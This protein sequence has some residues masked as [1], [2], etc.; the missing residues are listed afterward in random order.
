MCQLPAVYSHLGGKPTGRHFSVN[1]AALLFVQE[2]CRPAG[3]YHTRK[4]VR[5]AGFSVQVDLCK[6]FCSF[7]SVCQGHKKM[8][9]C[10]WRYLAPDKHGAEDDLKA[11]EEVITDD[12]DSRSA[13]RPAF[14]GAD[15]FDC[16]R[17]CTQES[18]NNNN[19]TKPCMPVKVS[20]IGGQITI[21]ALHVDNFCFASNCSFLLPLVF[22]QN[23]VHWK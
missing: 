7:L 8:Y 5:R 14:T 9:A 1:W 4:H 23:V 18:Y 13:G 19:N 6:F 2:T 12:D 15:R 11:V 22:T 16:R 21:E 20:D 3:K 10:Q 17:R